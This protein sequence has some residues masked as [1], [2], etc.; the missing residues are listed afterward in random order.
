MQ[1]RHDD[2]TRL[3]E[4]RKAQYP[5][6]TSPTSAPS[7]LATSAST[8]A[9]QAE[10]HSIP[11][12]IV[13]HLLPG[14]MILAVY[15]AGVQVMPLVGPPPFLA[16]ILAIPVAASPHS[17]VTCSTRVRSAT[18]ASHSMASCS[19]ASASHSGSTSSSCYC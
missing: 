3:E 16:L 4:A 17:S 14:V 9:G 12:T 13:L 1:A 11:R 18:D 6:P 10:Q 8:A 7:A 15:I 5:T 19:I 2:T